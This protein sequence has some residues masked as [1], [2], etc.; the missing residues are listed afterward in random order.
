MNIFKWSSAGTRP[1]I[2]LQRCL[3]QKISLGIATKEKTWASIITLT[4]AIAIMT[5]FLERREIASH[6]RRESDCLLN[7]HAGKPDRDK[8]ASWEERGQ[9]SRCCVSRVIPWMERGIWDQASTTS[10]A[11]NKKTTS[12]IW[13]SV[14]AALTKSMRR[15]CAAMLWLWSTRRESVRII[16]YES[17]HWLM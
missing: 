17:K 9:G 7:L 14:S 4:T 16:I 5:F 8:A 1:H 11:C 10:G 12:C 2:V 6:K 15:E 13:G 3:W